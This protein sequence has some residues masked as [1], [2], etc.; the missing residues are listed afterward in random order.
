MAFLLPT[1]LGRFAVW[2]LLSRV[3]VPHCGSRGPLVSSPTP[4]T[5]L[6]FETLRMAPEPAVLCGHKCKMLYIFPV[7]LHIAQIIFF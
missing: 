2:G 4:T 7:S 6:P 3:G 5:E 1:G